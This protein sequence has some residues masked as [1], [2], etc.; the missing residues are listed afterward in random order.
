MR[1]D[2]E[3]TYLMRARIRS[4][5]F[6]QI[7]PIRLNLVLQTHKVNAVESATLEAQLASRLTSA[8]T[9]TIIIPRYASCF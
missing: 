2:A 9:R 6:R 7:V 5:R 8:N 4:V 1:G 3:L